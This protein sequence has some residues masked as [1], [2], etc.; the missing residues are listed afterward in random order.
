M[1]NRRRKNQIL[2][3]VDDEDHVR[4]ILASKSTCEDVLANVTGSVYDIKYL[5]KKLSTLDDSE[6]YIS[7]DLNHYIFLS[8]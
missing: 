7:I 8:E 5:E 4:K 3:Y 1:T 6:S 2:F